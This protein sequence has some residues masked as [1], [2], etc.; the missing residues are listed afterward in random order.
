MAR[1]TLTK[2][3]KPGSYSGTGVLLTMTGADTT[4]QNQF[5]ATGSD[6]IVARNTDTADHTVTINST[7]DR[8]GRKEDIS[9]YNIPAGETHIFGPL[10][11][12]GWQ[13]SDGYIYLEADSA[14]VEFGIINVER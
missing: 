12:H 4:N 7:D 10:E 1:T 5:K 9:A 11:L 14:T 8:F 2:T 6:L 13:Q 3:T